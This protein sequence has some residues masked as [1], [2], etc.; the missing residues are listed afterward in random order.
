MPTQLRRD[1]VAGGVAGIVGGLLF[2]WALTS[3]GMVSANLGLLGLKLSGGLAA[4]HVLAAGLAGAGFGA[5]AKYNPQ[6]N[7]ATISN[8]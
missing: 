3:Q 7:A 8:I 5:M 4:L 6:G 2:W 1:L